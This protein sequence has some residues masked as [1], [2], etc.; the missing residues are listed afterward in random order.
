MS[1]L[2]KMKSALKKIKHFILDNILWLFLTKHCCYCN[3][4]ID[5]NEDMC[6]ACKENLPVISGEKCKFCGAGKDRCDCKHHKMG[7]D[8]ITS[9]FYYEGGIKEGIRKLKFNGKE[10]IAYYL[11]Q[12][13]AKSVKSD[14]G[15]V[16]F[17]FICFVPFTNV[18]KI[19]RNYNQSEL[20][21]EN[22]SKMLKIPLKRVLVK[23]FETDIQHN[24]SMRNR[25]GNI[26]GVY[27]VKGNAHLNG[28]TVL[29]VDDIKTTGAT[30]DECAWLLKI[31][32][33]EKVYCVTAALTGKRNAEKSQEK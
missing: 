4:V 29:L 31:R 11:A 13:M 15:D 22:L 27:D 10:H 7:Y 30:L 26:F 5:K 2:Q 1:Q 19:I 16:K 8:G 23:L 18:Q 17:D 6:D 12:D 32:G 33:A 21:A 9:P 14:F 24:M 20:L 25:K 3:E 28:K